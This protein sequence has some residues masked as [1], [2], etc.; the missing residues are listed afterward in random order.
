MWYLDTGLNRRRHV[1]SYISEKS[2][3]AFMLADR[4]IIL[5]SLNKGNE[6]KRINLEKYDMQNAINMKLN[7]ETNTTI[8][9]VS[10]DA[11]SIV[12][13]Y[14]NHTKEIVF[15]KYL[16][17]WVYNLDISNLENEYMIV[18]DKMIYTYKRVKL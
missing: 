10:K 16:D 15:E 6:I 7:G 3:T 14:D 17:G 9:S 1:S 2:M 5:Y 12:L 11:K 18:T 4:D 8:M 13:I